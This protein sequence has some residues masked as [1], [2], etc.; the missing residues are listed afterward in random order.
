VACGVSTIDP[1]KTIDGNIL[2]RVSVT[3]LSAAR[4]RVVRPPIT[5]L[6]LGR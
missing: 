3:A 2:E 4:D 5:L 6:E 1:V